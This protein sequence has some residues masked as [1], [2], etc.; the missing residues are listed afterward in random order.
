MMIDRNDIEDIFRNAGNAFDNDLN[1]STDGIMDIINQLQN[2]NLSMI[3]F[4][5][6]TLNELGTDTEKLKI[7][8][9]NYPYK[10]SIYSENYKEFLHFIDSI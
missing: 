9:K 1:N 2:N 8:V 3:K 6:Y 5:L 4:F 7:I 10:D